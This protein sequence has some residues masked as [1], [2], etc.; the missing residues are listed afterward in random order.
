MDRKKLF[1]MVCIILIVLILIGI[2]AVLLLKQNGKNKNEDKDKPLEEYTPAE[3]ITNEQ[4][5]QTIVTL[6]FNQKETNT[7]M[8][9]ARLI[10]AKLLTEN[11]Y[12]T[13][14]NLL[15]S[16]PKNEKLESCI[17]EGTTVIGAELKNDVVY[18]N[19][20]NEFISKHI[21]GEEKEKQTIDAIV[22]TL[23]ELNEVN[24]VKIL[25]EGEENLSFQDNLINFAEKFIRNE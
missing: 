5:R 16:E 3:E 6:Y 17:P 19:L 10:D 15:I 11:P 8:P 9:E 4:I 21:G 2:G 22:N 23:T 14:I 18:L 7:L 20:S 1:K 24:A 13:L 12:I 25:I